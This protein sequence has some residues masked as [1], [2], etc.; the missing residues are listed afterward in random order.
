MEREEV[1]QSVGDRLGL[2]ELERE[3]VKEAECVGV[4]E[5]VVE[6]V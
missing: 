2:P 5:L 1:T 6:A 4:L 3:V